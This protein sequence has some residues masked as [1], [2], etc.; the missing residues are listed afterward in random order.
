MKAEK[1]FAVAL[2]YWNLNNFFLTEMG[3]LSTQEMCEELPIGSQ[4]TVSEGF[5]EVSSAGKLFCVQASKGGFSVNLCGCQ[6]P[7]P[8][9]YCIKYMVNTEE[10]QHNGLAQV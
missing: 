4:S 3:F 9:I 2:H 10:Q 8:R 6:E 7:V 5:S 1:L